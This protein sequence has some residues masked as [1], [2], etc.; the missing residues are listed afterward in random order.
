MVVLCTEKAR[1]CVERERVR[2]EEAKKEGGKEGERERGETE[3]ENKCYTITS[4]QFY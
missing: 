2:E 4:I 3:R 1:Y